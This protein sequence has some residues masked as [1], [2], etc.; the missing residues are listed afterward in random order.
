MFKLILWLLLL[1]FIKVLLDRFN[2]KKT[3]NTENKVKINYSK[4]QLMTK[5]ERYF[6]DV[7]IELKNELDVEVMPQVNLALFLL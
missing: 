4:K 2:N 6:Y 3:E 1:L 7:L 5:Y